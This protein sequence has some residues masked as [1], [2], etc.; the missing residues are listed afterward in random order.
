MNLPAPLQWRVFQPT[1][2]ASAL[3]ALVAD[4]MPYAWSEPTFAS[5]NGPEYLGWVVEHDQTPVAVIV[6]RYHADACEL[7]IVA[8]ARVWQ[9]QGIARALV[10]HLCAS[11]QD[12][13]VSTVWLE[14]RASNQAAQALYQSLGFVQIAERPAYYPSTT[15]REAAW[16]MRREL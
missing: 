10:Q 11:V 14:V 5:C 3:A 8:V 6:A 13:G 2:D 12:Q 7:L 15:G 9:Q 16:V 1:S 4:V